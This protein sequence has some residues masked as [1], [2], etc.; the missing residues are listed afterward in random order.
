MLINADKHVSEKP[1]RS[2]WEKSGEDERLPDSTLEDLVGKEKQGREDW[3][4]PVPLPHLST[5]SLLPRQALKA[6]IKVFFQ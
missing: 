3:A 1:V 6:W 5:A 4:S 2:H